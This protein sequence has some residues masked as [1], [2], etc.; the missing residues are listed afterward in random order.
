MISR[1]NK[2]IKSTQRDIITFGAAAT[3]AT[4]TL[5]PAVVV[6]KTRL[7]LLGVTTPDGTD[8]STDDMPYIELTNTTTITA[9][10]GA[11]ADGGGVI[12]SWEITEYY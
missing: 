4:S 6:A 10:R 1:P 2:R 7:R 5:S 3:T 8:F 9:T 12:V 11:T